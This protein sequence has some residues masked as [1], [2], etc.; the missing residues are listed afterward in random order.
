LPP[1]PGRIDIHSHL[2]PGVDDGCES[3]EASIECVRRL[4]A[5]GYV[6]TVCT[7]HVWF[8][9]YPLNTFA[10]IRGW[11]ANLQGVL[12]DAGLDY[13]IWTGGELRLFKEFSRWARDHEV[14]TLANSRCVLFDFWADKWPKWVTPNLEWLLK[15]GYQPI[16]AH[17]ERLKCPP[18]LPKCLQ[19]V[20]DMGV[21][22]Q[23][24]FR[25]MTG[26]EGY[27]ADQMVRALLRENKY[28]F[29]AMDMHRPNTLEGRIDGLK[30]VE[31]EFGAETVER[32]VS[33]A[34]RRLLNL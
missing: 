2:L 6:G 20:V 11:V 30:M 10:H 16:L 22:L 13:R 9:M 29:L 32:L 33:D 8:E 25:C 28:H 34:P 14:P 31:T 24:N 23:G 17:P 12:D 21:W 5:I 15:E 19:Q 26:E 18:D 7:P 1:A 3:F 4:K 27:H